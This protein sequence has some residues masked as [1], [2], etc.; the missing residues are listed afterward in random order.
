MAIHHGGQG[1][2]LDRDIDPTSENQTT[3]VTDI[4]DT[5]DFHPA[6]TDHFEDLELNNPTKLAA[7]TRELDDLHQ[8]NPLER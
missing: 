2:L 3:T 4:E 8:L 7:I 5:Q 6:E 1:N